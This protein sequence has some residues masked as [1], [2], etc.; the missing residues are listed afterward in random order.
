MVFQGH[1]TCSWH[2]SLDNGTCG[3]HDNSNSNGIEMQ[4]WNPFDGVL[5]HTLSLLRSIV[6]SNLPHNSGHNHAFHTQ[7]NYT[8]THT[9]TLLSLLLCVC[10]GALVSLGAAARFGEVWAEPC[11]VPATLNLVRPRVGEGEGERE[12]EGES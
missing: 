5:S 12:G 9:H 11:L 4:K 10:V 8:H 3:C 7:Y 2:L 1:E 6:P